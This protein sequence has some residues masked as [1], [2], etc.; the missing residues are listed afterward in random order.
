[1][2]SAIAMDQAHEQ[3]NAHIK[4]NGGAVGLTDNPR[5]LQCRKV[6]GPEMARVVEEFHDQQHHC[7]GK[8]MHITM[9]KLQVSRL[10]LPRMFT[11]ISVIDDLGNPFEEESTDVLVLDTKEISDKTSVEAVRSVRRIE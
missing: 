1:M 10:H 4:G 8:W 2:F 6:A 9:T 7:G 11:L 3:N 5:T